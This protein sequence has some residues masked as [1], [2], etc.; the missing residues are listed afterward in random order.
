M[1]ICGI[2]LI[3]YIKRNVCLA[4]GYKN[5]PTQTLSVASPLHIDSN[6]RDLRIQTVTFENVSSRLGVQLPSGLV[7]SMF[8]TCPPTHGQAGKCA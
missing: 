2:H 5:Q 8:L 1:P 3:I 4:G 7:P 6:L